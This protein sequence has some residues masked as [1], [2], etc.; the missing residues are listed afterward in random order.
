MRN[1]PLLVL[2]LVAAALGS[3]C[4]GGGDAAPGRQQRPSLRV[5][6]A[7]VAVRD[8]VY[9]IKSLG[10]IEAQDVV[11]VTAQVEGVATEVR[12]REGDRVGPGT[13]LL[14]IDP[15]RYRLEA[16][17][18]QATL[19]QARAEQDRAGADL[20]RREALAQNDLLSAEE[21]N[22]SRSDSTRLTAS[23]EVAQAALGI[24]RQN[25]AR[26]EVRPQ[27]SGVID[28]RTVDTGQFVRTG[29]VLGTIVDSSRLRLRFKVSE[30]ESLRATVGASVT[31]RVAPLGPRDFTARIYHVGRIADPTTRN[32]E[33][34]AW[35]DNPG[36]LKPGFFAEVT[37]AGEQRKDA[38]V[39]PESAV[40]ASEQGFVTYV[41]EDKAARVRPIQ[42]G[43]RTGTGVVEI[44]SGLKPGETV[45][46]EGSD[47]L[48]DGI[49]V[50]VVTGGEPGV[51]GGAPAAPPPPAR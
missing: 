23:V 39:V 34:L 19:E 3:A 30:A 49:P 1:K 50:E 22:R 2:P 8:V 9:Q 24:A 7:P 13:V 29:T 12:F 45:V 33:V 42:L 18:A 51:A 25:V 47:R 4:G 40:Q 17:R 21:L 31:F 44:L 26:S 16:E 48:D 11:Q 38:L 20:R 41:V 36:E 10:Q 14:R 32:V 6:V 43:L 27:V 5:R 35:V 37:L 15:E 46:T 28:T